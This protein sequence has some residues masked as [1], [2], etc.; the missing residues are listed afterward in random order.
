ML[1]TYSVQV[2]IRLSANPFLIGSSEIFEL[3]P[4]ISSMDS[5][6]NEIPFLET[7]I[8]GRYNKLNT[9]NGLGSADALKDFSFELDS[10]I[11]KEEIYLIGCPINIFIIFG[12]DSYLVF[13]GKIAGVE[14]VDDR[15]FK[16][17]CESKLE[18][19]KQIGEDGFQNAVGISTRPIKLQKVTEYGL[20][21]FKVPTGTIISELF[22]KVDSEKNN[23]YKFYPL[24]TPFEVFNGMLVFKN[25]QTKLL[26]HIDA[27]SDAVVETEIFGI[28][29]MNGLPSTATGH[30]ITLVYEKRENK[31]IDLFSIVVSQWFQ[32]ATNNVIPQPILSIRGGMVYCASKFDRYQLISIQD[33]ILVFSVT[34][35]AKPDA[36]DRLIFSEGYNCS[37]LSVDH[38]HSDKIIGTVIT[39]TRQA[40]GTFKVPPQFFTDEI[41]NSLDEF[42]EDYWKIL[43]IDPSGVNPP[44]Y[45]PY[46]KLI[47]R[48]IEVPQLDLNNKVAPSFAD[49]YRYPEG[50]ILNDDDTIMSKVI[51]SSKTYNNYEFNMLEK[52]EN[53]VLMIGEEK[54]KV[55][56]IEKYGV[57]HYRFQ[58]K[59]SS[60]NTIKSEHNIGDNIIFSNG[61][62]LLKL[63]MSQPINEFSRM[64]SNVKQLHVSGGEQGFWVELEKYSKG[65]ICMDIEFPN[66]DA[67]I[68]GL[69]FYMEGEFNTNQMVG[70]YPQFPNPILTTFSIGRTC[71][72]NYVDSA[73]D[74]DI[75]NHAYLRNLNN[76]AGLINSVYPNLVSPAHFI[77]G[78]FGFRHADFFNYL[79]NL[80]GW[81]LHDTLEQKN[82]IKGHYSLR[83]SSSFEI[84]KNQ[85]YLFSGTDSRFEDDYQDFKISTMEELSKQQF[86]FIVDRH[87]NYLIPDRRAILILKN[88]Q[89]Y[90]DMAVNYKDV[91]LYASTSNLTGIPFSYWDIVKSNFL[92]EYQCFQ[93]AD[94]NYYFYGIETVHEPLLTDTNTKAVVYIYDSSLTLIQTHTR[95]YVISVTLYM[96][97]AFN[98]VSTFY[99][100]GL[101]LA[102]GNSFHIVDT[103]S[104]QYHNSTK[105]F[106]NGGIHDLKP[107]YSKF[108]NMF[109]PINY[110]SLKFEYNHLGWQISA[111]KQGDKSNLANVL[112]S[113]LKQNGL[114]DSNIDM[115]SLKPLAK[116]KPV[117]YLFD[118]FKTVIE[119]A[120]TLCKQYMIA[121]IEDLNGIIRFVD[122]NQLTVLDKTIDYND[123][124]LSD[125][126]VRHLRKSLNKNTLI[127]E[128]SV[129]YSNPNSDTQIEIKPNDLKTK[130]TLITQYSTKVKEYLGTVTIS[131]QLVL[132]N[133]YS[134]QMAIKLAETF[135]SF[136]YRPIKTIDITIEMTPLLRAGD[137]LSYTE[138][139]IISTV[140]IIQASHNLTNSDITSSTFKLVILDVGYG[141]II[142]EDPEE[143]EDWWETTYLD[144]EEIWEI[145]S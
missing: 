129:K 51:P 64:S 53:I 3:Y 114:L 16:V 33:G 75:I 69:N 59:R 96:N 102:F 36:I 71:L 44:V 58:V 138:K 39:G 19:V 21:Y 70:N 60:Y 133:V 22:M 68:S 77:K 119:I 117:F 100:Q 65:I 109:Y 107:G 127:S 136:H 124:L 81:V 105:W 48:T 85:V 91:D 87:S 89:I 131:Y 38:N 83:G 62:N 93:G 76:I 104:G 57:Y 61:E 28:I 86:Y 126:G 78:K 18:L 121:M 134:E 27:I 6:G 140:L 55:D 1:V 41:Q 4:Y 88:M 15:T 37:M 45:I 143:D 108:E 116:Y 97:M 130:S 98:G 132:D 120:N 141:H 43:D 137:C 125:D 82:N 11:V 95:L 46:T 9:S 20:T 30:D 123:S 135:Y 63:H 67:I 34:T 73:N 7:T 110:P 118:S 14:Q 113:L 56:S 26:N 145:I 5:V 122:L 32:G 49:V 29:E 52:F 103:T 13:T 144:V 50:N 106:D 84:N 101:V 54:F 74:T 23:T 139:G 112:Y 12:I 90:Y 94:G 42:D 31:I 115:D 92:K 25:S 17:S 80:P 47:F 10:K 66:I 24:N 2:K 8:Q 99:T 142:T 128:L 111:L 72:Q 35:G 40:D 79:N